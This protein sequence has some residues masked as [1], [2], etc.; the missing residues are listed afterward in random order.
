VIEREVSARADEV[1]DECR[2]RGLVV[3]LAQPGHWHLAAPGRRGTLELT[4]S[5]ARTRIK[6]AANRDGGWAGRLA[7]ELR[8]T[9]PR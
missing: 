2:R 5:G 4:A 9:W 6:V 8:A 7:D 3:R 1:L